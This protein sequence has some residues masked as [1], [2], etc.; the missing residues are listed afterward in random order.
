MK[1][2]HFED[3]KYLVLHKYD[4]ISTFELE[5]LAS[6]TRLRLSWFFI[7][8]KF[9]GKHWSKKILTEIIK[10]IKNNDPILKYP[11]VMEKDFLILQCY[12]NNKKALNLYEYFGFEKVEGFAHTHRYKL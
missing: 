4:L 8:E 5:Q 1:I 11:K 9:R 2:I 12:D 6:Q 7:Y 10:M 3:D